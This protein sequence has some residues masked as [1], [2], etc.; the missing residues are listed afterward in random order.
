MFN[1]SLT[2]QETIYDLALDYHEQGWHIIPVS[3]ETKQPLV[4]SW[5]SYQTT[6]PEIKD[7]N[8]WFYGE[9]EV[10]IALVCAGF[11]VVDADTPEAVE[12]CDENLWSPVQVK[13]RKGKHYYFS[14]P[15]NFAHYVS[16]K[17]KLPPEKHIDIVATYALAPYSTHATGVQY[18]PYVQA[19]FDFSF[20]SD[21]PAMDDDL[22]AK[23]RGTSVGNT[24]SEEIDFSAFATPSLDPVHEGSR[25][26]TLTQV[27]GRFIA[28]GAAPEEAL[29]IARK[30]NADYKPPL[31]DREILTI[32]RS[33]FEL[34]VKKLNEGLAPIYRPAEKTLEQPKHILEPPGIL[35]DIWAYAE[36]M[37]R[38]P[39]PYLSVNIALAIGSIACS[40]VYRTNID[41]YSSLF[42]LNIAKSGQGK[43]NAKKVI[44][45]VLEDAGIS[46]MVAGDGYTSSGAVF[47]T[48][49]KKPAHI[50]IIDEFGRRL[51]GIN[52][53]ESFHQDQAMR[54]LMESWGRCD[55]VL[56]PD[57]YST[58]TRPDEDERICYN[59]AISMI[60]MTVPRNFYSSI[61]GT[62]IADGFLNRF[63]VV[64]SK[65]ERVAGRL[66]EPS[67]VPRHIV[68]WIKTI[69]K[70][71][72]DGMWRAI[73]DN[74]RLRPKDVTVLEFDVAAIEY[75][76][77]FEEGLIQR[78]KELEE[79]GLEVLLSRTREKA[80]RVS[81]ICALAEDPFQKVIPLH[82]VE[83]ACEYVKYYD[84]LLVEACSTKVASSVEEAKLKKVLDA[85]RKAGEEG[86]SKR[87]VDRHT[88]FRSM[89]KRTV[90][91][92][93][94]RLIGSGEI[95]E[96]K[97]RGTSGRIAARY[98]AVDSSY[99]DDKE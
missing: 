71:G 18:L 94:Q 63:L 34:D 77:Q 29:W 96:R 79:E 75:L 88:V 14:N 42:F 49:A 68:E 99:F 74:A 41:N 56:R 52:A 92:I 70:V 2:G 28:M 44:E 47:S 12:W 24:K 91:E 36:S 80:M 39:Q 25:N 40:R 85:V 23:I 48:L 67:P 13:T 21:L 95:Q 55:G 17:T 26:A 33:I 98:I 11:C 59:P 31:P 83:W 53:G 38:T 81:L 43:E 93:I 89:P 62:E 9:Q 54:T 57:Q 8:R 87:D 6:A 1:N 35:A 27:V 66:I 7:I 72:N 5:K 37:A 84:E 60:G 15:K 78:Q 32:I 4:K 51:K 45:K 82:C 69:R 73:N 97:L 19:D 65:K 76:E 16:N 61:T 86:I 30:A 58:Y 50:V 22:V 3:R 90:M 10:N 20:V 46:D 64:E